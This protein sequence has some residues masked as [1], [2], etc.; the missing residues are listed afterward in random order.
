MITQIIISLVILGLAYV[1]GCVYYLNG[2]KRGYDAGFFDGI[3]YAQNTIT[4]AIK[5]GT[6]FG[7]T[8]KPEVPPEEKG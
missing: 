8:K 1:I 2:C 6:L 3:I 4:E 5:T 7:E